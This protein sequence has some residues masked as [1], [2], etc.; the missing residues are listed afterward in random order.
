M[1]EETV[2]MRS[3]SEKLNGGRALDPMK[4]NHS[5]SYAWGAMWMGKNEQQHNKT[6]T[7]SEV[8]ILTKWFPFSFYR[9][10]KSNCR[11]HRR[12]GSYKKHFRNSYFC[13]NLL[14]KNVANGMST[15]IPSNIAYN[16]KVK[17]KVKIFSTTEI[18]KFKIKNKNNRT[19]INSL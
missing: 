14:R 5:N 17:N 3:P 19:I 6:K 12:E 10:N 18:V 7:V 9:L 13:F 15:R 1:N 2:T 11:E 4:V 16:N 8:Y